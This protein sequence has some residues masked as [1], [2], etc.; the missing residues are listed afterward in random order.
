MKCT[1]EPAKLNSQYLH[2]IAIICITNT[3]KKKFLVFFF[4]RGVG[5]V[6]ILF[7][8]IV[9]MLVQYQCVIRCFYR[10]Y[11]HAH[12]LLVNRVCGYPI[13]KKKSTSL[14]LRIIFFYFS[15]QLFFIFF[16]TFLVAFLFSNA[17]LMHFMDGWNGQF[18][19][20]LVNPI[21]QLV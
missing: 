5:F 21:W 2:Y 14:S 9:L 17:Y 11:A 8:I 16:F 7:N 13:K 6:H 20:S 3:Q 12:T 19:F 4:H 18:F 1:S 10:H 15:N